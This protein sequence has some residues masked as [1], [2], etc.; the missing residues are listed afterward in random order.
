LK[1]GAFTLIELMVVIVIM[2]VIYTLGITSFPQRDEEE[3][4]LTLLTLKEYLQG[5]E[6]QESAKLLCLDECTSCKILIDGESNTT[7]E[8][9][10]DDSIKVYR[11]DY[12]S[13]P[14]E[15]MKDV[16]FNVENIQE[17]VCFSYKV[18]KQG[19][20]DQVLVEYKDEVYDFTPYMTPTK[21]YA[22]LEDAIDAK[23]KIIEE[24]IK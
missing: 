16:Y 20:G 3:K 4:H 5:L 8:S 22:S 6:F 18:D 12:L 13:G 7:I 11:Y 1:K 10:I 17:D 19:I 24:V 14:M 2:G 9:F 21:K 23:A 15:V